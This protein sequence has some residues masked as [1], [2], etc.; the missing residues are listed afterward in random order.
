M[1]SGRAHAP[2]QNEWVFIP[3]LAM[4]ALPR[5]TSYPPA[6]RF[7]P[8][9]GEAAAKQ[10]LNALPAGVRL[11]LYIHIPYC[12]QLCWYCGCNTSVPTRADPVETYLD[13]LEAEI[14]LV[15][16]QLPEGAKVTHLHLGGGSPD[17]LNAQQVESLFQQ[18][19]SAFT[20]ANNISI[21]AELDPRGATR[22]VVEALAE[23]GLTR[24]SFGVQC[25]DLGVQSRINRVQPAELVA[26]A[27]A[28]LRVAGVR[29]LNVDV[30]YGLPGQTVEHV[31]ETAEFAA[32]LD[33]SRVAVF[34]YAHVPWFKK[35]QKS[36]NEALLPGGRERF[37]QAEAA[38]EMLALENYEAIGFDHYAVPGDPMAIAAA[39]GTLR[40][41]FQGY[42]TDTA[43]ALIGLGASAISSLPGIFWQNAPDAG[44]YRAA[45]MDGRMPVVRGALI[46]E[47][48]RR[49][50]QLIAHILCFGEASVPADFYHAAEAR[51]SR[52]LANGVIE[53]GDDRLTATPRGRP[54]LRN[55][56]ASFDPEIIAAAG[57]HSLAV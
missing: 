36:I 22:D 21:D 26:A 2:R 13:A 30:M 7:T 28:R 20:F 53:L 11:S 44:S 56:A 14:A 29:D 38:A 46:S 51:L 16:R 23:G 10:A 4:E 41:N 12:R 6:N 18:L 31:A 43:A 47:E 45:I 9:V 37:Q 57:R 54:Y 39:N 50:A 52:L 40:R 5:Y 42:T 1:S 25:L 35:H 32:H 15:A 34:G 8:H 17:T 33:A 55:I 48:D 3:E 49:R 27:A 24:A 19:R